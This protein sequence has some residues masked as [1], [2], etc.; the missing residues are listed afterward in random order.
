MRC[1][2][3]HLAR[4]QVRAAG[5][6][7]LAGVVAFGGCGDEQVS[8]PEVPLAETPSLAVAHDE[9]PAPP[10][11]TG[12]GAVNDAR[13]RN[14]ASE[15][16]NW[17]SH[18]R[19]Y[20][21]QRFSPLTQVADGNVA[22]L[23]R[24]WSFETG[25]KRGHEATPIVV[26]GRMFLTGAWSVV[27]ALDAKTGQ[28]LWRHD[29]QVPRETGAKACC[30]VVNRGVA[31]YRGLVYAGTLDG[32]LQAL[33]AASGEQVWEAIT[34]DPGKDYTVTGAPRVVKG[35]VILGNGGAEFGV[36]GYVSAYDAI[37]GELAWRT[38]TVP[39]DPSKP[40]ESEALERAAETW[41]GEWWKV[42]GGGTAWDSMAYDPDLDLLYVG[43]GNGSPWSKYARSPGG[44]DNLYLSSIL[45]LEPDTGELVWH[46]QTT[47][48][49]TWDFTSTQHMILADLMIDG[50]LRKVI[51]QAPKNGFFWV[52]DR[53]TGA[54][55]S[56]KPYV[57]VTWADGVDPETGRP[58]PNGSAEYDKGLAVVQP[59]VFGGHNWQPMSFNPRTG[60]V[61]VPAQEII[62]TYSLAPEFVL[63]PH[64]FNTGADAGAF[65]TLTREVVGGHLLAW[66]PVNQREVWRHPY[67]MPWNG[68]TLTTAGNLVFQGTADGRFL[69]LRADD[70]RLLWEAHA[71]S[72]VIA[73]PVSYAVDGVQ[74][75]TVVA[76]WGGAFALAGG[77]AAGQ[78]GVVSRGIVNTYAL[79]DQAIT[80]ALVQEL[81]ASRPQPRGGRE[82]LFHEWCGRCHGARAVG[83]G[84]IADLRH[85]V[86]RLGDDFDG[87]VS[88][89]ISGLGM[90]GFEGILRA[91]QIAALR[92]YVEA[93]ASED[94]IT[95]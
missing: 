13:L 65:A 23:V 70:G 17:L 72:G 77:D 68:G 21:E 93:R 11:R 16:H 66:D 25:L 94:R 50:R 88:N 63:T 19:D 58:I 90:P 55:I 47:P 59:T 1:S 89:G 9:T 75:V 81:L 4:A 24:V 40:F 78:A 61:Y 95:P 14:A 32:R 64:H 42:G 76:G 82:D 38:Y 27:F 34:V 49:D 83:S 67:A 10:A 60:L 20:A 85:S 8:G 57:T 18:G 84:V 35:K 80:P 92:A 79:S 46:F 69:A 87:L 41:S 73:A 12:V 74:Y 6:A 2:R 33:D 5:L 37:T 39:G 30:D 22:R 43:T 56:A 53:E 51:M 31:V 91:D 3:G 45:A 54:F 48:G 15:A 62:G 36:R 29:P 71:G 86:V 44:G 52:L 28:L 7:A 26:D